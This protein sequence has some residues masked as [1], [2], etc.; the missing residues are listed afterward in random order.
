MLNISILLENDS[1][2]ST[3][4]KAHGL[5]IYIQ[6]HSTNILLDTGPNNFFHKNSLKM[7]I[8]LQKIDYCVL[9]HSHD[10]H[11]GGINRFSLVNKFAPIIMIDNKD[12]KF[13]NTTKK[14]KHEYIGTKFKNRTKKRLIKIEDTYQITKDIYFTPNKV[15]Y[16]GTP[17]K[18][19]T[20]L[21]RN[22]NLTYDSFFHEGILIILD[23]EELVIF[24]SCSHTG[25]INSIETAR[26][27]L[28]QYKIRSYV[29]GFHFPYKTQDEFYPEDF[30]NLDELSDYVQAT[31][32]ATAFSKEGLKLYTGHCTGL[33]AYDYLK[34]TL[35]ENIT[36]IH[37]GESINV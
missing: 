28:P 32:K 23:E 34:R 18:N 2:K 26:K 7:N 19:Q 16:F 35:N 10:D 30:R 3:I 14:D 4:K 25:V 37:G 21:M 12:T 27:I 6:A 22:K 36:L 13:F 33:A 17:A 20:L 8:D 5:S 15:N 1:C 9:S 31:K 29:G 11:C 24:N